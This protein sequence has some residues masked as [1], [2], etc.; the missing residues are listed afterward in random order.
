MAS[1]NRE[2]PITAAIILLFLLAILKP[3]HA[4]IAFAAAFLYQIYVPGILGYSIRILPGAIRADLLRMLWV[5]ASSL[6][7]FAIGQYLLLKPISFEPAFSINLL[8]GFAINLLMIALPE[9]IFYR[10]FLQSRLLRVYRPITAV[11]LVNLFFALGHFAGE[12]SL[13][14]LLPF[15][16]GLV[17]SW[18]VY[19]SNGSLLG[20][21]LYHALCNVFGEWLAESFRWSHG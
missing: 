4:D 15:F 19:K 5:S 9:E 10:G 17:F 6:T 3:I 8:W 14:R 16:P 21:T 18:L 20:A 2:R 12:Y 1:Q 13:I 7:L 11:L